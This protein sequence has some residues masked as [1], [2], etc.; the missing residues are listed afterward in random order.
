MMASSVD[1]YIV[2]KNVAILLQR[3]FYDKEPGGYR[4]FIIVTY[5]VNHGSYIIMLHLYI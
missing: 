5:Q 2:E 3:L 4:E 1:Y